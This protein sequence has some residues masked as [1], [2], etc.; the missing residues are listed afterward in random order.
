MSDFALLAFHLTGT[1]ISLFE[2]LNLMLNENENFVEALK[3]FLGCETEVVTLA[4]C[5]RFEIYLG[6]HDARNLPE[7]FQGAN[8]SPGSAEK[9]LS[10][11]VSFL[12]ARIGVSPRELAHCGRTL[13]GD[14]V[15]MHLFRTACGLDSIAVGEKQIQGQVKAAYLQARETGACGRHLAPLFESALHAGKRA[16]NATG[17]EEARISLGSM[18]IDA[19]YRQENIS[20]PLQVVILGTG[21]MAK[22]AAEH[23]QRRRSS[24]HITFLSRHP[25]ERAEQL[26]G[27]NVSVIH[28]NQ[29]SELLQSADLLF[30]AYG[31]RELFLTKQDL[32]DRLRNR[33]RPFY[34]IDIA[35][36]RDVDQR[37]AELPDVHL[38]DFASLEEIKRKDI[39][40]R[41]SEI[42]AAEKVIA[43]EFER[44]L[45]ERK[46][47]QANG[48][49]SCFRR[50]AEAIRRQ[51]LEK[52][53]RRL[54]ELRENEQ[55][56]LQ[57]LT[58]NIISRVLRNP[59]LRLREKAQAGDIDED[60]INMIQEIF[61]ETDNQS[62][63][64]A[65]EQAS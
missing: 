54:P 36:P 37:V 2:S 65:Q 22:N 11:L 42:Q 4:T 55:K 31:T 38:I 5:N 25:E 7:R 30:A 64:S 46:L 32:E 27:P 57:K 21:K 28:I 20:R 33:A 60:Y 40:F 50:H 26:G 49:I 17:L 16:R 3:L 12:C 23:L 47:Q 45:I 48:A 43:E 8:G 13:T 44:F 58:Y 56:V 9:I 63:I 18:A 51:E 34:I 35:L 52:A 15:I 19:L 39:A 62:T 10:A 61:S 41:A 14:A 59:T 53:F 24:H 6:F 29:L 1:P